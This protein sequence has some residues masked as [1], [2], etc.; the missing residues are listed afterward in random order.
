[1]LYFGIEGVR[2]FFLLLLSSENIVVLHV[3]WETVE[4]WR[5]CHLPIILSCCPLL[6]ACLDFLC[7]VDLH[8]DKFT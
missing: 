3:L 4:C 2:I 7:V 8:L 6:T 5:Q 1:M